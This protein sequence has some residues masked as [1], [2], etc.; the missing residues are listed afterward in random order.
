MRSYMEQYPKCEYLIAGDFNIH[1][2][3]HHVI[4]SCINNFIVARKLTRCDTVYNNTSFMY[5]NEALK[6][7]STIDY[8]LCS[9][10]SRLIKFDVIDPA[11]NLS[12]HLPLLIVYTFDM[13]NS[14]TNVDF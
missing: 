4:A 1:L 5:V 3:S 9:N 10:V 6:Q 13:P 14:N 11:K 8:A 2:D 7:Q 12:D